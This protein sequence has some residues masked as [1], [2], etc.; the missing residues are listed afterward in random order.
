MAMLNTLRARRAEFKRK[1]HEAA[2]AA[3]VG[4]L[5]PVKSKR[6]HRAN[7]TLQLAN[8]LPAIFTVFAAGASA[9]QGEHDTAGLALA[10]AELIAGAGV[11]VAIALEAR[12]LFGRH[13]EHAAAAAYKPPR[14]DAANL[15][16]AILGYVEAWH[17]T[18]VS[19]HFK[20]VSPQIVGGT[21]SLLVA[22]SGRHPVSARRQ[23]RRPHV[24]ITPDG[25]SYL[26]GRRRRWRAE[27]TEVAAV[28][29]DH[30]EL[31]VRLHDGRRHVLRADH[32]VGGEGVLA[33]TRAA[34]AAHAPQV[35]HVPQLPGAASG[36]TAAEPGSSARAAA[37]QAH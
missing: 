22:F 36:S 33:E 1:Y 29:H 31:A 28:E 7:F 27:W 30:G 15:A 25:I 4:T 13:A 24:A 26:A 12:H 19:G 32:H 20:L 2:A 21:L 17:R 23:R 11:L 37:P 35:Q 3:T 18:H 10:G 16:A 34:I 14:V 9:L 8:E 6:V 5:I